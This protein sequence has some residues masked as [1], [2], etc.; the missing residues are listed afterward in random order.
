MPHATLDTRFG[1][2]VESLSAPT[3]HAA[4]AGFARL[5][6]VTEITGK[7][8]NRAFCYQR[9]LG[10]LSDGVVLLEEWFPPPLP[11]SECAPRSP[12]ERWLGLSEQVRGVS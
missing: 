8:R 7:R 12:A 5:G 10:N 1:C 6:V 9:I 11:R 4:S 3:V 2:Y